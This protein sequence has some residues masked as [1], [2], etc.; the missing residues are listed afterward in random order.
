MADSSIEATGDGMQSFLSKSLGALTSQVSGGRI[1]D[2]DM[3]SIKT[4]LKNSELEKTMQ[5][6]VKKW[7][8]N[9]PS[10]KKINP[11]EIKKLIEDKK[12]L[13]KDK[14]A[15][16]QRETQVEAPKQTNQQQETPSMKQTAQEQKSKMNQGS[17][18]NQQ[19][20][21]QPQTQGVAAQPNNETQEAQNLP[22][23]KVGQMG[24]AQKKPVLGANM[25]AAN[26]SQNL[27]TLRQ[28]ARVQEGQTVDDQIDDDEDTELPQE[29][30]QE[31]TDALIAKAEI[32]KYQKKLAKK[33]RRDKMKRRPTLISGPVFA[34]I[35]DGGATL[36]TFLITLII[37]IAYMV[38]GTIG[39]ALSLSLRFFFTPKAPEKSPSKNRRI[40]TKKAKRFF[41]RRSGKIAATHNQAVQK[42]L[43][44]EKIM[45]V[46]LNVMLQPL[47]RILA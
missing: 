42:D 32:K 31:Q 29:S 27:N 44:M 28:K 40:K 26:I 7:T 46:L 1:S 19:T 5:N 35:R 25:G 12:E 22:S 45:T 8:Q 6:S 14:I 30:I 34:G 16:P 36:S 20:K 11:E 33:R 21:K 24:V 10:D 9:K 18:K 47:F 13:I 37:G 17:Q 23:S 43:E 38:I 3:Q 4:S 2:T 39:N 15:L 41:A